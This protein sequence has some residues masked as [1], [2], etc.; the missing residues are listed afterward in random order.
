LAIYGH[1]LFFL[2]TYIKARNSQEIIF[3]HRIESGMALLN[4]EVDDSLLREFRRFAVGKH[5]RI[6]GVLRPE[7][8]AALA[9]HMKR[10]NPLPVEN[11]IKR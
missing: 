11:S 3:F 2:S 10:Q 7:V 9:D 1:L 5:G 8:E 6:Y 4:V